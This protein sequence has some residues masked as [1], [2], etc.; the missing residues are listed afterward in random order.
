MSS[1]V[2][3]SCARLDSLDRI[4]PAPSEIDRV[5]S[6]SSLPAI[7]SVRTADALLSHR[8]TYKVLKMTESPGPFR[9]PGLRHTSIVRRYGR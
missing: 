9:G 5:T 3:L 7:A 4:P 6:V 8:A 1:S 2:S